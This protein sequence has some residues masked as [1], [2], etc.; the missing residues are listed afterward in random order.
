MARW[1]DRPSFFEKRCPPHAPEWVHRV[2]VEPGLEACVVDDL[3]TLVWVANLAALEL[4][5]KQ[6]TADAPG[7]PTSIV[8]DL[9]P[10]APADV[11]TC[12]EGCGSRSGI[13]SPTWASPRW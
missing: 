11:V 3:P 7:I 12:A 5:T 10:G 4:H 13:S 2:E 9:D 8:F 1:G 6:A